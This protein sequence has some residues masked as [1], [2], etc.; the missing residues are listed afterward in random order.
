MES[1]S[2]QPLGI[3]EIVIHVRDV[4]TSLKFYQ[5]ILRFNF[6]RE[7]EG[8]AWLQV[9]K[10]TR[11]VQVLLHPREEE[12]APVGSMALAFQYDKVD[13]VVDR[14]QEAGVVIEMKPTNLWYGWYGAREAALR[15]P[16][17]IYIFLAE[18]LSERPNDA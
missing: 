1:N 3:H 6:L 14:A 15:D 8:V 12:L 13:A 4:Q 2:G 9:G 16:D 5:E 7:E 17:G 18:P 11:A 10:G